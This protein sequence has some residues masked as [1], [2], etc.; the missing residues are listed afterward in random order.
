MYNEKLIL[1]IMKT[2]L[3]F[4]PGFFNDRLWNDFYGNENQKTNDDNIVQ[5]TQDG[6]EVR[7]HFFS[8]MYYKIILKKAATFTQLRKTH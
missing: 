6:N 4:S 3:G 5:L 2:G 7:D 1:S 8:F